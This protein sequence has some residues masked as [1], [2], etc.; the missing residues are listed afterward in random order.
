MP[1]PHSL[2]IVQKSHQLAALTPYEALEFL[3]SAPA[4][5]IVQQA[6]RAERGETANGKF[7]MPGPFSLVAW[8][9]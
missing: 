1:L 5:I 2:G 4:R 8:G 7:P 6:K 3:E 9:G